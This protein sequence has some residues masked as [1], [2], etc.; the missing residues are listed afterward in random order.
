[1]EGYVKIRISLSSKSK[2]SKNPMKTSTFPPRSTAPN[3][4]LDARFAAQFETVNQSVD[5]KLSI[6]SSA[7]MSKFALMLD[8]FKL[9]FNNASFSGDPGVLGLSVASH[10]EPPSLQHHVST[11]SRKDL[12]FQDSG[13]D[14]VPHGSGLA[15]GGDSSARPQVRTLRLLVTLLWRL[16]GSR[17][18]QRTLQVLGLALLIRPRLSF[19]N[20]RRRMR[21]MIEIA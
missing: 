9:G 10:T 15:Q 7:L 17:S 12:R 6:M 5:E 16:V 4:D 19:C 13:V 14:P 11:E 2:E 1:M 20:I 8:Q 18:A 21:K 3:V